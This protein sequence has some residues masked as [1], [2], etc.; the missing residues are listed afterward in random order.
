MQIPALLS[1]VS[2]LAFFSATA[3][4]Q[5]W[6]PADGPLLTRWAKSVSPDDVH[7]EYPRPQMV[8]EEWAHLNGLWSYAVTARKAARPAEAEGKILVPFPIESAL[9]GV[10][11][12]VTAE[13]RVWCWRSV[14]VPETWKGK[15]LLLH[16][17]AVDWEAE[18]WVD[19]TRVGEH[20]GGYDPFSFDVTDALEG[21]GPHELVVA[22]WDPTSDGYQPRGKQVNDP[23]GIW[24]TPTTG[25]WRT[26]WM[27]PVPEVA[28]EGLLLVTRIADPAIDA[29]VRI[30]APAIEVTGA[31]LYDEY[32]IEAVAT[33]ETGSSVRKIAGATDKVQMFGDMPVVGVSLSIPNPKL[34]S[35][36]H[37]HL[38]DLTLR[39]RLGEQIV[40]EVTSYTGI[41]TITREQDEAGIQR[42]FLNGEPLFHY[43]PLDQGFWP[44]GLYAAPCDEALRYDVEIT[45]QLGFNAVRKHVKI[46][47]SR[48]YYWCDKLGLLVWQ[49]MPSGDEYIGG[50]APDIERTPESAEQF[51]LELENN[52]DALINH[53]SIVMWV[54]YNE[55]WGQWNTAGVVDWIE[56]K[57]PTRLVNNTSGW[58]DRAVGDVLDIHRYPGPGIAPLEEER[59]VVLGEF[60]GLGLPLP[61][62]TWQD[63]KNWGY[64][65]FE[66]PEALTDAYVGLL[67]RLRPLI[68]EGLAAAIYTQTSDVE[69]EVN[70]LMTYDRELIKMDVGRAVEAARKLYLPP[71]IVRSVLETSR[72]AGQ[73]WRYTCD[74]PPAGW[75]APDFDDG[76]WTEGPGGF[77]TQGTPGAVVRTTWDGS[78]IWLRRRVELPADLDT[79]EL[80]LTIHHD[81]DAEVWLNGVQIAELTGYTTSYV[82][83]PLGAEAKAALR[84]GTNVLA[85]HCRQTRGGQYIDLGLATVQER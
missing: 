69:I 59:A 21:D 68:G 14:E 84:A 75:N 8:R 11:R 5:G 1:V 42:L 39:L 38:Y 48:W 77:G 26:V 55:G 41:R 70:G 47:P 71:P 18:V 60:G 82:L 53:P 12:R 24:Y 34:W 28:I 66:T 16:F 67:T 22:A 61:G 10:M 6:K 17:G 57:D 46:E 52:I 83:V 30:A 56:A 9:S 25:M 63:E 23:H 73:A 78:D 76:G 40:D 74:A 31:E 13:E 33:D 3:S 62:H 29:T 80:Q 35:P 44:D 15:R 65:S 79:D 54:P 85:V 50:N 72:K 2:L 19:G 81:E 32:T 4:A 37:P 20:R 58:A 49:D 43:G 51:M 7:P 45:K 27:E 64:R 36:D